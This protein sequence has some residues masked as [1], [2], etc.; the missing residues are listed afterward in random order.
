MRQWIDDGSKLSTWSG[1]AKTNFNFRSTYI[2]K[3]SNYR[4][5]GRQQLWT[6]KCAYSAGNVPNTNTRFNSADVLTFTRPKHVKSSERLV[7]P[8]VSKRFRVDHHFKLVWTIKLKSR[9]TEADWTH[10]RDTTWAPPE[11]FIGGTKSF[12]LQKLLVCQA[13]TNCATFWAWDT[14]TQPKKRTPFLICK[15]TVWR[16]FLKNPAGGTKEP[17]YM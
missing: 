10:I 3:I 4:V 9:A 16:N 13:T 1:C 8:R 15:S 5:T 12:A 6:V 17:L 14:V 11:Q 7:H 2:F